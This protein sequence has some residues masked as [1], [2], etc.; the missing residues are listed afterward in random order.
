MRYLPLLEVLLVLGSLV[1]VRLSELLSVVEAERTE[2]Y[3][4]CED[5]TKLLGVG[6]QQREWETS[7]DDDNRC[8]FDVLCRGRRA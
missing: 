4:W 2:T 3:V 1:P 5:K 6:G 7:I 8:R